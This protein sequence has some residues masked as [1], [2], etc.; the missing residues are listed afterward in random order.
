MAPNWQTA[1]R[2]FFKMRIHVSSGSNGIPVD[3]GLEEKGVLELALK[4]PDQSATTLFFLL[5]ENIK[6]FIL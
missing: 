5:E 6:G 2:A 3:R 1:L 4:L